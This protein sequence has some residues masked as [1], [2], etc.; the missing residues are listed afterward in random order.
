MYIGSENGIFYAVDSVLRVLVKWEFADRDG[1]TALWRR[2][3]WMA[4]TTY[5][6]L[7][8]DRQGLRALSDRRVVQ[9]VR[10]QW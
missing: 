10:D 8:L 2:L 4:V 1:T 5:T 9:Y 7:S 6:S 3:S